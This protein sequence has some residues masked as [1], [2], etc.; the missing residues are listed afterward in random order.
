MAL[1][2]VK[3]IKKSFGKTEVLKG[4]SFE[5]D[6][7][8]VLAIIGS[9]GSGK[10]TLLR[11]TQQVR[12]TIRLSISAVQLCIQTIRLQEQS[13][14]LALHRAVL[15]PSKTLISL[16]KWWASPHLR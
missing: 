15:Q 11:L 2:E 8:E 1:L 16:L 9:S 13:V 12:T 7:G 3:D 6:R 5:L 14:D 4:I 10:T